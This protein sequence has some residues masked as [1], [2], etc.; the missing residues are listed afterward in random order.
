MRFGLL[1]GV[2][3]A[4]WCVAAGTA[5]YVYPRLPER[6][7]THWNLY[8]QPDAWGSPIAVIAFGL[9]LPLAVYGLMWVV[10]RIDPRRANYVRFGGAYAVFRSAIL[11]VLLGVFA[12]ALASG[13]GYPVP[14][15]RVVPAAVGLLLMVIGDLMGQVRHNYFV[16]I[17]T[18]WTLANEEVWRRTH[19]VGAYTFVVGGLALIALGAFGLGGAAA[20][21]LLIAAIAA[22]I[23]VPTVYS[24]LAWRSLA[25][26][27]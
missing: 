2:A 4:L 27:D 16:G 20:L 11:V 15:G 10:P 7:P 19:R 5:A 26:R 24:Y 22:M 9:S 13:A 6:V 25:D 8:G 21:G 3:L 12:A 17:R 1:D 14:I 18:P 23:L